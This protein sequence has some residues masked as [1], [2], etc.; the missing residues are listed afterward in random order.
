MVRCSVRRALSLS[1]NQITDEGV[2]LLLANTKLFKCS[3]EMLHLQNNHITGAGCAALVAALDK[4]DPDKTADLNATHAVDLAELG[5]NE[6][7]GGVL[8]PQ[9]APHE[10]NEEAP[11]C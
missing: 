11:V 1:D 8:I 4:E 2:A 10:T 5:A 7:T 6:A 3:L 9:L